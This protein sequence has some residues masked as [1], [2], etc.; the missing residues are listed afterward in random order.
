[1]VNQMNRTAPSAVAEGPKRQA[2]YAAPRPASAST[3]GYFALMR[4][5]HAEHLPRSASQLTIGTFSSA[6]MRWPQPGQAERG[7]TRL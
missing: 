6:P 3:S 7:V 1:M 4:V 5:P 2:A